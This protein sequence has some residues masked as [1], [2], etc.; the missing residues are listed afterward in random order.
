MLTTFDLWKC[1]GR[2][3][4]V[5]LHWKCKSP[6]FHIDV[7]GSIF[8][9][10]RPFTLVQNFA[11]SVVSYW[12]EWWFLFVQLDRECWASWCRCLRT[13]PSGLAGTRP[14]SSTQW[15][16]GFP[17][18][19]KTV[20]TF[21]EGSSKIRKRF[22]SENKE[23]VAF[24]CWFEA[25][26]KEGKGRKRRHLNLWTRISSIKR[27]WWRGRRQSFQPPSRSTAVSC[28]NL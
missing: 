10:Y 17:T 12:Q 8:E 2:R 28:S 3:H 6:S 7:T 21:F 11:F 23:N 19:D 26:R 5:S 24:G 18:S 15:S 14:S 4:G 27:C 16:V 9:N 1:R 13:H 22:H 25:W 20:F